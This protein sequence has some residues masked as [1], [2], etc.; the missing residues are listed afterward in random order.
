M[1]IFLCLFCFFLYNGYK[2][3]LPQAPK[4]SSS[5]F[6]Q[7]RLQNRCGWCSDFRGSGTVDNLTATSSPIQPVVSWRKKTKFCCPKKCSGKRDWLMLLLSHYLQG[8]V[9]PRW[10]SISSINVLLLISGEMIQLDLR[11]LFNWVGSTTTSCLLPKKSSES[12]E[13]LHET[14]KFFF[15]NWYTQIKD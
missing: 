6:N 5:T 14:P 11:R 1:Y 12:S 15:Q 10:C 8:L 3:G 2:V 13:V 9:H 7:P 4:L